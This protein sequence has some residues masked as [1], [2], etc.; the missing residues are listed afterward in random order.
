MRML[1]RERPVV[2][3]GEEK[4]L[5]KHSS[6]LVKETATIAGKE[7][8]QKSMNNRYC[9][10]GVGKII[11]NNK[12]KTRETIGNYPPRCTRISWVRVLSWS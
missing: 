6:P 11:K 4:L 2:G 5:V 3:G 7:E 8:K 9:T 10:G 1:A 12:K